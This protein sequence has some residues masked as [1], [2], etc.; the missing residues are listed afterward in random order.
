[1]G[2]YPMRPIRHIHIYI[3]RPHVQN[4]YISPMTHPPDWE[5]GR[6]GNKGFI[7]ILYTYIRS[8]ERE[9]RHTVHTRILYSMWD[10][11]RRCRGTGYLAVS[12]IFINFRI[13]FISIFFNYR[14]NFI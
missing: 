11:F 6:V 10:T 13:S 1:M 4:L 8:K 12:A 7:C 3:A 2:S 5:E 14:N 9:V